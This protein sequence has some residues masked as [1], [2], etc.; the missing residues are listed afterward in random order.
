MLC[1]LFFLT[2]PGLE[3]VT[4]LASTI[5]PLVRIFSASL[6]QVN[7]FLMSLT[8]IKLDVNRPVISPERT[9][10]HS[11]TGRCSTPMRWVDLSLLHKD[12]LESNSKE[13]CVKQDLNGPHLLKVRD[14]ASSAEL[15]WT[16]SLVSN[17]SDVK[18][19]PPRRLS[20][21]PKYLSPNRDLCV[22]V[23]DKSSAESE[24]HIL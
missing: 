19:N 14:T 15:L 2:A 20:H 23:L 9:V 21:E 5:E 8:G 12:S 24:S 4:E 22:D 10:P 11:P 6:L 7:N 16:S 1:Y 18:S 13:E 17:Q 3:L